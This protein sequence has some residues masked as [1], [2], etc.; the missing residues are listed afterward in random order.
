MKRIAYCKLQLLVFLYF[1]LFRFFF[2][3]IFFFFCEFESTEVRLCLVL[4]LDH[5]SDITK[6]YTVQS[7]LEYVFALKAWR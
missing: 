2:K 6:P 7:K 5:L 1:F 3:Y 4:S